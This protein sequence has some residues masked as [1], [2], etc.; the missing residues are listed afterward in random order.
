MRDLYIKRT[1]GIGNLL[2]LFP[3][4][5]HLASVNYNVVLETRNDWVDAFSELVPEIKITSK[6]LK[7]AIDLDKIT[8]YVKPTKHRTD[9]FCDYF[10]I[11]V[12]LNTIKFE[13]PKKWSNPFKDLKGVLLFAPEAGHK[14]RQWPTSYIKKFASLLVDERS[15][16]IGLKDLNHIPCY[17]DL[18]GR[19]SLKE[20]LGII[21]ISSGVVSMDSGAFHL[22]S[23]ANIPA[24][25]IFSGINP[26]FRIKDGQLIYALYSKTECHPCNKTESCNERFECNRNIDPEIVFSKLRY[27]RQLDST[28]IEGIN[29]DN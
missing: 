25:V 8:Y 3:V 19:L 22:A 15:V 20:L 11:N 24:I 12:S 4:L 9:E 10:G 23:S 27:L 7:S 29:K 16:L 28:I 14:A 6:N 13:I 5:K 21:S 17:R 1:N 2:M 18:R 26:L